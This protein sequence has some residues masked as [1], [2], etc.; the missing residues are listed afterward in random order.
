MAEFLAVE[1]NS[2]ML[3]V[4]SKEGTNS[5]MLAVESKDGK[6]AKDGKKKKK[7]DPLKGDWLCPNS[8]VREVNDTG[9]KVLITIC[10]E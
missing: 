7:P 1:S 4:E 2:E 5:A 6:E 8:L 10:F 3:A 9:V